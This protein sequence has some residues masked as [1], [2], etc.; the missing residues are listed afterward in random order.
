MAITSTVED[1]KKIDEIE[2]NLAYHV[3]ETDDQ[4]YIPIN[5]LTEIWEA[6]GINRKLTKEE[7]AYL[8]QKIR[9][10]Y[11]LER[12]KDNE[13]YEM[14][15]SAIGEE[16]KKSNILLW[17]AL[18]ST[19]LGV[20]LFRRKEKS[21]LSGIGY[22]PR[23]RTGNRLFYMLETS[24]GLEQVCLKDVQKAKQ[25][26]KDGRKLY[27][28]WAENADS[29][30]TKI[31]DGQGERYNPNLS[32]ANYVCS[33]WFQTK[34][35]KG[36]QITRCFVYSPKCN[37]KKCVN[38]FKLSG[39]LATCKKYGKNSKGKVVCKKYAATCNPDEECLTEKVDIPWKPK[40]ISEKA[41]KATAKDMADENN[42]ILDSARWTMR[43][44]L[45]Y[46]GIAPYKSGYLSE[47]YKDIPSKYKRKDGIPIDELAQEMGLTERKL[48]EKINKAEETY[49]D[50][51]NEL[52]K[53][54]SKRN[55]FS[56]KDFIV[57][58]NDQLVRYGISGLR[59]KVA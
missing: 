32:G 6:S 21:N 13:L 31:K 52:R 12:E 20:L 48:V 19:L 37:T 17:T 14:I 23:K 59:R 46:G 33:G 38:D 18:G 51:V 39:R 57:Q 40:P 25:K 35:K 16:E 4:V 30:R 22:Y 50:M 34:D 27:A 44:V 9:T 54:G 7:C 5:T 29:A 53:S 11:E 36:K 1:Y 45:E 8:A 26:A 43:Q 10:R 41:I 42:E 58:A 47:E 56:Y 28:V 55:K 3:A 15:F 24:R 2:E 49:L